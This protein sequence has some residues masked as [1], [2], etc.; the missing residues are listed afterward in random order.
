LEK[1][2][3]NNSEVKLRPQLEN[4]DKPKWLRFCTGGLFM[5]TDHWRP[6]QKHILYVMDCRK[7]SLFSTATNKAWMSEIYD[8]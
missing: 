8:K 5:K 1:D 7:D 3:E 2:I 6:V 4:Q